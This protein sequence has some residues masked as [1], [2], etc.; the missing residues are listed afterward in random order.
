MS[1]EFGAVGDAMEGELVAVFCYKCVT[2]H[3]VP[4]AIYQLGLAV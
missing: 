2:L 3:R 1:T 4:V